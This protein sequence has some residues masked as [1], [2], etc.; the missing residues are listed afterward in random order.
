MLGY[1]AGYDF[2]LPVLEAFDCSDQ[3]LRSQHSRQIWA[4]GAS[5]GGP[6]RCWGYDF[7]L[8]TFKTSD[9]S[10]Q[11]LQSRD[12]P[13]ECV[14]LL[15]GVGP[16]LMGGLGSRL[17]SEHVQQVKSMR[18]TPFLYLGGSD[19]AA[20]LHDPRGLRGHSGLE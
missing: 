15:G 1:G 19:R 10:D 13:A 9:C 5:R 18:P 7:F 8:P 6:S 3:A 17:V 16:I 20:P 4:L 2:L 14:G 12:P 11:A